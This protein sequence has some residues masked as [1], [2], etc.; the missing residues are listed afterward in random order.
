[1]TC[2]MLTNADVRLSTRSDPLRLAELRRLLILDS[3]VERVYDDLTMLLANSLDVPISIINILDEERDWF[4][5]T[6]GLSNRQGSAETSLCNVFF[7]SSEDVVVV[8]DATQDARFAKHPLVVGTPFVRFY[9]AA[10]LKVAGHTVGTLCVRDDKPRKVTTEQIQYIQTL[11]SA[12]TELL[13][14]R[15]RV[16]APAL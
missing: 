6:V 11:A 5:S 9:A 2:S 16:R 4:K 15:A 7:T 12:V 1:M 3:T 14:Q 13:N 10:R 8:E